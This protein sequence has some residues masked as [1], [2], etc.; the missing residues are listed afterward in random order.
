VRYYITRVAWVVPA[1]ALLLAF[2]YA[3]TPNNHS[4]NLRTCPEGMIS[5][6]LKEGQ[7]WQQKGQLDCY[8]TQ[9]KTSGALVIVETREKQGTNFF[10]ASRAY[11][12][13]N[14]ELVIYNWQLG[15]NKLVVVN[16]HKLFRE[17]CVAKAAK[18][19]YPTNP[20]CEDPAYESEWEK[21][22]T[23]SLPSNEV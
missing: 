9:A 20:I 16:A 12:R 13:P 14:G 1:I 3:L 5:K 2:G 8:S 18:G 19:Y 4:E 17:E 11:R 10:T 7:G 21:D 6:S 22:E 15:H 23:K